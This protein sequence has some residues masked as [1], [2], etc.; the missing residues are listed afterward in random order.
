M[1]EQCG[2]LV[3]LGK[4]V[5]LLERRFWSHEVANLQMLVAWPR[6]AV[7]RSQKPLL[8][9]FLGFVHCQVRPRGLACPFAAG[10]SCWLKR[11][12]GGHTPVAALESLVVLQ[13]MAPEPCC[14]PEAS[15]RTLCPELRLHRDEQAL[16]GRWWEGPLLVLFPDQALDG[17]FWRM[18]GFS[19]FIGVWSMV[20]T[21]LRSLSQQLVE[22][23]S[24]ACGVRLAVRL[25]FLSVTLVSD[26]E[27]A[28]AQILKV[29]AKSVPS[30]P[31][32]VLRG[33]VRRLVWCCCASPVGAH[34]VPAR[35][36]P[37]PYA[38]GVPR[39]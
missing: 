5:D 1:L 9:S 10:D 28:I 16:M 6:L 2:K 13:A 35:G 39:R 7:W 17:P 29:R 21:R 18:G 14:A 38:G 25:G 12:R 26:L 34:R 30:A 31:Q 33:P 23:Q 37:V 3:C 8:Q 20:A 36:P 11:D 27:M 4:W 19:E 24:L 22:L 32:K 15:V